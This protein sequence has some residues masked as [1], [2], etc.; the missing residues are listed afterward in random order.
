MDFLGSGK[1]SIIPP[2]RFQTAGIDEPVFDAAPR[3]QFATRKIKPSRLKP[4]P[5]ASGETCIP[6]SMTS[7]HL[8]LARLPDKVDLLGEGNGGIIV[9]D[10]TRGRAVGGCEGNA[11]VDVEHALGAAWR[12]DVTRGG[13]LVRLGVHIA[14]LPDTAAADGSLGRG[15]SNRILAEEVGAEEGASCALLKEGIAVVGALDHRELEAT[16]VL[17]PVRLASVSKPHLRCQNIPSGSSAAG[18]SW[19]GQ[20]GCSR[21]R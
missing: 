21:V 9:G 4:W 17:Q 2:T 8:L 18:S 14:L 16:G 7:S 20:E 5:N 6:E 19:C 12:V 11:V 3:P 13:H 15:G 1:R 10:G